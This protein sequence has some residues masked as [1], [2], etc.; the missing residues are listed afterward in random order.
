[1]EKDEIQGVASMLH[2][3]EGLRE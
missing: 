1:M 3:K 2:L